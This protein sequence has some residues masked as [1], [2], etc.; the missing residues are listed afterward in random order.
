MRDELKE[1]LKSHHA[2][3]SMSAAHE[4]NVLSA[5]DEFFDKNGEE[6]RKCRHCG[7]R[8]DSPTSRPCCDSMF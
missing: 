6:V 5:I 4:I 8:I 1:F 7:T 2:L 3:I